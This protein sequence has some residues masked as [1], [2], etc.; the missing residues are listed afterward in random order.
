MPHSGGIR[1]RSCVESLVQGRQDVGET[2]EIV[3]DES[4]E[5]IGVS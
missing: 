4:A 1:D 5:I 3:T 2:H